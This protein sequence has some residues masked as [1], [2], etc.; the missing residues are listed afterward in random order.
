MASTTKP[1]TIGGHRL[2]E[3]KPLPA[4]ESADAMHAEDRAGN[5][6]THDA[7]E[8]AAERE[9]GDGARAFPVRIPVGEVKH[10]AG[11]K[12][13]LRR[14]EEEA[15]HVKRRG[16]VDEHEA[17]RD[18]APD[19]HDPRDPDAR[20]DAMQ[21]EVA[22]HFEDEIA[23]EKEARA[24][25]VNAVENGRID[26]QHFLQMQLGEADIDAVDV[27]DDVTEKEQRQEAPGDLRERGAFERVG[28]LGEPGRMSMKARTFRARRAALQERKSER[29]GICQSPMKH[30]NWPHAPLSSP[31]FLSAR[32]FRLRPAPMRNSTRSAGASGRM[33]AAAR[34]RG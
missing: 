31:L 5:R 2:D 14:A 18:D 20:A 23:D 25:A 21:D 9:E 12:S 15:H 4:G 33:N 6:R 11:E 16:A 30:A 26:A 27:G 29:P 10:D 22:R 28:E 8:H 32:R 34:A 3:E 24:E 17:H 19:D 7:G 13:G 1:M